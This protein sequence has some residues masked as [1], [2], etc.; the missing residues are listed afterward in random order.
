MTV[1]SQYYPNV[2]ELGQRKL[3]VLCLNG[4][5]RRRLFL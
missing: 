1:I 2:R 5:I 3:G 4:Y